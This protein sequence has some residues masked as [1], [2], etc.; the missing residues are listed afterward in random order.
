MIEQKYMKLLKDL[1]TD[2]NPHTA[3]TLMDHLRGTY[4]LLESW[5]NLKS[6]CLAGLFHSIY[7]TQS[8]Q[9][10][11]ATFEQR[12]Q[13]RQI[14]GKEAEFLAYLFCVT[15]RKTF[16]SEMGKSSP[17]LHDTIR[18]QTVKIA[19][20]I[21]SDLIEIEM[22]NYVEFLA[23]IDMSHEE[24]DEFSVRVESAKD[25]MS[26]PAYQGIT[27][28]MREKIAVVEKKKVS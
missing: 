11:S 16:F 27:Q 4:Q 20:D 12:S 21:L 9:T 19:P 7:G 1:N 2:S 26:R 14:I 13:I 15:R 22:A 6:V 17:Q 10:Q 25:Q 8:Y 3:G 23:R 5:G 24:L 18:G 28:A